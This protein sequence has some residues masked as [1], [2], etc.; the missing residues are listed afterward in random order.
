MTAAPVLARRAIT[1]PV[2]GAA[3]REHV[4]SSLWFVPLCIALGAWFLS[5]ASIT[6]DEALELDVAPRALLPGDA[7]ALSAV[8]ATIAAAMLTFLGVVF[9]TTL[10]AVQLASSQYSPRIVRL[11]VRSRLTQVTLGVFLA[12]FLFALNTLVAIRQSADHTVPALTLSVTYLL[13]LATVVMFISFLHGM[14]RLLR[15]QHL[16]RITARSTHDAIDAAFPPLDE[17]SETPAPEPGADA[18]EVLHRRAKPDSRQS[19]PR[20]LQCMDVLGLARL[21][22]GNGCWIEMRVPV[23]AHVGPGTVIARVHGDGADAIDDESVRALLLFG[24]ERS[25][26]Q[27][28]GFGFRQLIDISSRALSPAIND[29]TT[30]VQA[31]SRVIDLLARIADRPDPTGWYTDDAGAI[32]VRVME[33]DFAHLAHLGLTEIV[34]YGADAPQVTRALAAAYDDLERLVSPDR[35]PVI[36]ALRTQF[37]AAVAASMPEAFVEM[38]TEPDRLGLG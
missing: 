20:V 7:T 31:L 8:A 22:A 3:F 11:F 28:P 10:V 27:D 12:T 32:R 18:R 14:V 15:V 38:A 24:S 5:R 17:Y 33:P 26:L 35:R 6:L 37:L 9:T 30:A 25:M 2:R 13:V 19:V 36:E 1:T 16:L 29:P 4:L 21:A 34:R 23:G